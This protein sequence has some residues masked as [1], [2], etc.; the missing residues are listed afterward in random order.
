MCSLINNQECY[1]LV[2]HELLV[3]FDLLRH[4]LRTQLISFIYV[5]WI[6]EKITTENSAQFYEFWANHGWTSI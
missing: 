1:H 4:F 6:H 3:Y 2:K 5:L